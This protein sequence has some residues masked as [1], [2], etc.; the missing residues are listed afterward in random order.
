MFTFLH[1]SAQPSV[2]CSLSP[3]KTIS[4]VYLYLF[5]NKRTI[6]IGYMSE[7]EFDLQSKRKRSKFC[8]TDSE[9]SPSSY[10]LPKKSKD[11]PEPTFI[12]STQGC[13]SDHHQVTQGSVSPATQF[14]QHFPHM[15]FPAPYQSSPPNPNHVP[16]QLMISDHDIQRLASAVKGLLVTEMQHM[17]E[18]LQNQIISLQKENEYL[19]HEIDNLEMYSRRSC[20]RISGVPEE[21][22]KTDD[23]VLEIAAKLKVP[24]QESDIAVSHRVGPKSPTRPRQII[25]KITNY[26]LRHRLLK[27]SKD[28]RKV[29]GMEKV[30]INQDLTKTR[31][32]IAYEARQLVKAGKAKSTFIW[33]GKIFVIGHDDRKH[34]ILN[35]NDMTNLLVS[36]GATPQNEG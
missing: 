13:L 18:P 30:A 31:N 9:P 28:L 8:S 12:M 25:A 4:R 16:Q 17:I 23:I 7:S 35:P 3:T 26:D 1:I 20:V 36:L 5:T 34:K 22:D 27:A 2:Q 14:H 10:H 21:N 32:K 33:D 15:M 19:K 24:L 6:H 29:T 11:N